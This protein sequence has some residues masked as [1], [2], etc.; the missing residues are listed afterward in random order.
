MAVIIMVSFIVI[1]VSSPK[2]FAMHLLLS[3]ALLASKTGRMQDLRL[4]EPLPNHQRFLAKKTLIAYLSVND[5]RW[6]T[7]DCCMHYLKFVLLALSCSLLT[8]CGAMKQN[9]A[10]TTASTEW[11]IQSLEESFLNMKEEQRR[12][13]DANADSLAEIEAKLLA[14]EEMMGANKVATADPDMA[15]GNTENGWVSD[16]KPEEDAWVEGDKVQADEPVAQSSEEKPWD[17]VPGPPPVIPE[18]KVVER[19]KPKAAPAPTPKKAGPSASY[20][21][22]LALYNNGDFDKARSS[23]DSF[24]KKYP[25]SDLVPNALYWSGET[26][27]SQKQYPQ[28]ILAFKE[29]TGRY[30]KHSKAAAALLKIGMSYDRVGDP[31]NAV[32]YLRALVEDFPK[33]NPAALAR[34]ELKRLGG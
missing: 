14:L 19:T 10:T 20:E 15:N 6:N 21:A 33:S 24:V 9:A 11:R 32:F 27:Y 17:E 4:Q 16:L 5:L 8:A 2:G 28:A 29:V 23:F 25:N 22:A 30:P 7:G 18:P 26:Y 1:V 12:Q 13:A 31:N 34:K 3:R